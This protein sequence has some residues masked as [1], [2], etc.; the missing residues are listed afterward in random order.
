MAV[1]A[2]FRLPRAKARHALAGAAVAASGVLGGAVA[3]GYYVA[4]AITRPGKPSP[5]DEY[6]FTPFEMGVPYED[7]TFLPERGDH[8]VR[9]WWLPRPESRRV[10]IS[11]TGYRAKRADLLGISSALWRTGN[12]VL[13]FDFHGHGFGV[14]APVT[15]AYRELDD[16]L[17]ALDFVRRHLPDAQIGVIGFSMGAAVAIQ[18]TAR[19]PEIQALVADSSFATHADEVRFSIAQAWHGPAPL[20]DLVARITDTFLE[21]RAGYRHRDVEPLR[22]IAHIAPRPVL[23]IHSTGDETIPVEDAYRLYDAASEP[24]EL[25]VADA[26]SHCGTYF[27]DR[28]GYCQRVAAFFDAHLGEDE[29][30]EQTLADLAAKE[31][32]VT[33]T[34]IADSGSG[35][36]AAR[37]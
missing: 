30:G 3:A 5:R 36:Q 9:G 6:T 33:R 17:G 16:L 21:R 27:L 20:V 28:A 2:R 23:L 35:V 29:P 12:N 24:K 25:W 8:Y 37:D 22:E 32:P 15:L 31:Q 14:G 4:S 7:V 19:R 1:R 26:S 10:I 34:Q 13:L 18:A 11:C